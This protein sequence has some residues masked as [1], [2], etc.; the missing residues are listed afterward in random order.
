M[1]PVTF[2][3]RVFYVRVAGGGAIDYPRDRSDVLAA[4]LTDD[5]TQWFVCRADFPHDAFAT[6]RDNPHSSTGRRGNA[7]IITRL[8]GDNAARGHART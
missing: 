6:V 1:D 3:D 5:S 7:E 4:N 2:L 8:S